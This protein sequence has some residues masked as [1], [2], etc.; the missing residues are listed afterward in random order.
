[1][2][3]VLGRQYEYWLND[4]YEY[5]DHDNGIKIVIYAQNIHYRHLVKQKIF[6]ENNYFCHQIADELPFRRKLCGLTP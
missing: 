4:A 6:I 5:H 1:L 3:P 2:S